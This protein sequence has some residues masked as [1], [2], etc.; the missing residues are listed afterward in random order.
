MVAGTNDQP[1]GK[2]GQ[3]AERLFQLVA[4]QRRKS[5]ASLGGEDALQASLQLSVV[6]LVRDPEFPKSYSADTQ[7][8]VYGIAANLFEYSPDHRLRHLAQEALGELARVELSRASLESA[9]AAWERLL[10]IE[11]AIGSMDGWA[12]DMDSRIKTWE[13]LSRIY[14][15]LRWPSK[16]ARALRKVIETALTFIG[17]DDF[18]GA[19]GQVFLF[20]ADEIRVR[21]NIQ[22]WTERNPARRPEDYLSGNL[23]IVQALLGLSELARAW[24]TL[25]FG[26]GDDPVGDA[27]FI[28]KLYDGDQ[29]DHNSEYKS[30]FLRDR[31]YILGSIFSDNRAK[32]EHFHVLNE[33]SEFESQQNRNADI[34]EDALKRAL[35]LAEMMDDDILRLQTLSNLG[36]ASG[37]IRR[38]AD[39]QRYLDTASGIV[40]RI[41][42]KGTFKVALM[43]EE[44]EVGDKPESAR[45]TGTMEIPT[46]LS[47]E[48]DRDPPG[49][50]HK[51]QALRH[52]AANLYGNRAALARECGKFDD[53]EHAYQ[54]ALA[55]HRE[56]C[57]LEYVVL[58]L[59]NLAALLKMRGDNSAA[60]SYWSQC[61]HV[62]K[63]LRTRD[64]GSL[65]EARWQH[66]IQQVH[67]VMREAGC[68]SSSVVE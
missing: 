31:A 17:D 33:I 53:A 65:M 4:Q 9:A 57:D 42:S 40:D 55:M 12:R 48:F 49:I 27:P 24:P 50:V 35:Q 45:V 59:E 61:L 52:V 34:A 19:Q 14:R 38:L 6:K 30:Q 16:R 15:Q 56:L 29:E 25:R 36:L 18:T 10:G 43:S 20:A 11:Q 2:I 8:M 1:E 44:D 7:I 5:L 60:C 62:Y 58:D 3:F 67:D 13:G 37:Q 63:E 47:E 22:R 28:V 66:S 46:T 32:R 39:S 51:V 54:R 26:D 68:D 21:E 41:F 23:I 64:A